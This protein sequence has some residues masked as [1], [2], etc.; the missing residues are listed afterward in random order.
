MHI[1]IG[2][3]ITTLRSRGLT[4]LSVPGTMA[5]PGLAQINQT[6]LSVTRS[7]A[8]ADGGSPILSYDLRYSTDQL[9]WT[10]VAGIGASQ[11]ITGLA[12]GTLYFVQTRAVNALGPALWSAS[13]S[14]STVAASPV[15]TALPVISGTAQQGQT[16]T[17]TNGT[18]ANSPTG[19]AYQWK[20]A[21]VVIGGA[22][23][24]TYILQAS[25]VGATLTF[26]VTAS[27][28]SGSAT[29]ASVAT[30]TGTTLR[31]IATR[32]R[33]CTSNAATN[34]QCNSRSFHVAND[35]ISALKIAYANFQL[36]SAI[37]TEQAQ[38]SVCTLTASVEYP[39]GTFTQ[40]L[41]GGVASK[42]VADG[43]LIFSDSCTIAIPNGATFWIRMFRVTTAGGMQYCSWRN[44]AGG[45][46]MNT[47]PS[48][49][50]DLSMGGTITSS[51]NFSVPPFAILGQ[52]AKSALLLIG[53]SK[54][55][56]FNDTAEN[57]SAATP[58][59]RGEIAKSLPASYPFVNLASGGSRA[60]LW[61]T[62][63]TKRA[64]MLPYASD[65]YIS[66]G[67]NDLFV[68]A[69]SAATIQSNL[70][71][72]T[73]AII[74]ANAA[75]KIKIATQSHKAG[76]TDAFATLAN[77]TAALGGAGSARG[78]LN[79]AIRASSVSNQNNGFIEIADQ[80][81][82]TRDTGKWKVDGTASKYTA[83]GIHPQPVGY[84]LIVTAAV[85][86]TPP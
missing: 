75:A 15:N 73:A 22:S 84:D 27:N 82:D 54:T 36:T 8:P 55:H 74:A 76:S 13:A 45:D 72:I 24:N 21:G 20:R 59:L 12:A 4:V 34:R 81:E 77:Q 86:P 42:A 32:A 44:S 18:W 25:D 71:L 50:S 35:T 64:L 46:L 6:R 63:W 7:A 26:E 1:G 48:G 29:A 17:G 11:T 61:A 58:G 65:Y 49:L 5:A 16:L 31:I 41:F 9:S 66:L 60:N 30:A 80:T 40:I 70:G 67:H 79:A 10:V 62:Q 56:G 53:D 57:A 85:V 19:F 69:D 3:G 83:D 14:Q 51:G 78:V 43:D 47:A 39:S 33:A 28:A 23:A 2:I 37:S 68:S 38:G 52:T